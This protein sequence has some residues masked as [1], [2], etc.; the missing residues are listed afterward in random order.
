[1][2]AGRV[3]RHCVV[4]AR[5]LASTL[6]GGCVATYHPEY[7]PETR[8][9]FVQTIVTGGAATPDDTDRC[10]L[11][12]AG[13]CWRGCFE[14]SHGEACYLLGVMFETGHGVARSHDD[15]VRMAALA[16]KLGYAPASIDVD[17]AA[18]Y[19]DLWGHEG[20]KV[21]PPTTPLP[22]TEPRDAMVTSSGAVVVYGSVNGDIY[23]GR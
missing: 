16:S 6:L 13:A 9:S 23:L 17:M 19:I 3:S 2:I 14:R 1:M 11:G 20:T 22:R 15:A 5:C 7:H 12:R 10:K 21:P 4:L 18:P 8:Y